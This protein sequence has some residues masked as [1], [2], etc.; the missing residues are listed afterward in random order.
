MARRGLSRQ[1]DG[2]GLKSQLNIKVETD[3]PPIMQPGMNTGEGV[4][5]SAS[6]GYLQFVPTLVPES[7]A[8][9]SG[10]QNSTVAYKARSS[11]SNPDRGRTQNGCDCTKIG[12][13]VLLGFHGADP[14]A[15]RIW[16]FDTDA[17][18]ALLEARKAKQGC[19]LSWA[20]CHEG[21]VILDRR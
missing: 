11:G 18:A 4:W 21:R 8:R 20:L 10:E 13:G 9:P 14:H 5:L 7:T 3:M 16:S 17:Y 1:A 19:R 2:G 12:Y 6:L 15:V